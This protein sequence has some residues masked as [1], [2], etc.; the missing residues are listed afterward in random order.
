MMDLSTYCAALLLPVYIS[1]PL[2]DQRSVGIAFSIHIVE[3]GLLAPGTWPARWWVFIT[4]L[5]VSH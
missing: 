4:Y 5:A 2:L 1:V 3:G